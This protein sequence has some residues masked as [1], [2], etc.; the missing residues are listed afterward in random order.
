MNKR[1]ILEGIYV[2]KVGYLN[3]EF[4]KSLVDI[5][6]CNG[7]SI[8]RKPRTLA[9]GS[10]KSP[11]HQVRC[12]KLAFDFKLNVAIFMAHFYETTELGLTA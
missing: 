10:E 3:I 12:P 2:P 8:K 5:G 1:R 6:A 7:P 4:N 11:D 9:S